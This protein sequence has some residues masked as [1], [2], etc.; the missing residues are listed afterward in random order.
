[1]NREQFEQFRTLVLQE[2]SLQEKLRYISDMDEFLE[3]IIELGNDHGFEFTSQDVREAMQ[4]NR[5]VWIE[6][7]I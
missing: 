1:M 2:N 3:A 7:W 4:E 5:R 6:R